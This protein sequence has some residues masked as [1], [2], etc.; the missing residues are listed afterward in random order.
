MQVLKHTADFGK[1]RHRHQA[2]AAASNSGPTSTRKAAMP[3]LPP[4]P[5]KQQAPSEKPKHSDS[6]SSSSGKSSKAS[7]GRKHNSTSSRRLG[8]GPQLPQFPPGSGMPQELQERAL[9]G[10]LAYTGML[11]TVASVVSLCVPQIDLFG[12]FHWDPAHILLGFKLMA[13]V[14]L[15]NVLIMLPNYSSWKLPE[16][17]AETQQQLA[18]A[19][20]RVRSHHSDA[21]GPAADISSDAAAGSEDVLADADKL[22]PTASA[23]DNERD[24]A[25]TASSSSTIHASVSGGVEV[26]AAST[27]SSSNSRDSSSEEN[28]LGG[29][30]QDQVSRYPVL[31]RA[32]DGMFLAQGHYLAL[33]PA[34]VLPPAVQFAVLMA[35]CLAAE[36][37]YRSVALQLGGGWISD[38]LYEAGADDLLAALT[39]ALPVQP[40][41]HMAGQLIALTLL[42]GAWGVVV[43]QRVFGRRRPLVLGLQGRRSKEA[44]AQL[45]QELRNVG[46]RR[47]Q[48]QQSTMTDGGDSDKAAGVADRVASNNADEAAY[49]FDADSNS[50]SSSQN[51]GSSEQR[52][53]EQPTQLAASHEQQLQHVTSNPQHQEQQKQEFDKAL[54]VQEQQWA[55]R[56]LPYTLSALSLS[57]LFQGTRDISQVTALGLSF[58]LTGNLAA[59]FAAAVVNQV[60]FSALQ[61]HAM[62]RARKVSSSICR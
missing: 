39:T 29:W 1:R 62:E 9:A 55:Q 13:P 5:P 45:L 10:L 14:Y 4:R 42:S 53:V 21:A 38:R 6:N 61:Q 37:L 47:G 43:L 35:E 12:N 25:L 34:H 48:Q 11:G 20:S 50:E 46:E 60:L 56:T 7:S 33:N 3:Q 40:T 49:G 52:G 27:T 22:C 36:L 41:A 19:L 18:K 28:I 8:T 31:S 51:P 16:P 17:S 57:Q 58:V 32:K 23:E 15:L 24:I 44:T 26:S 30:L 2:A 54:E 59:P